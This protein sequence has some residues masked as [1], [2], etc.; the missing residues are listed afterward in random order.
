MVSGKDSDASLSSVRRP[1]ATVDTNCFNA[2]VNGG[3]ITIVLFS[4]EPGLRTVVHLVVETLGVGRCFGFNPDSQPVG[5]V[6]MV[7]RNRP[8]DNHVTDTLNAPASR[9]CRTRNSKSMLTSKYCTK[10]HRV[11]RQ[12]SSRTRTARLPTA[13]VSVATTRCQY[14]WEGEDRYPSPMSREK[15]VG[16][17]APCLGEWVPR[18]HVQWRG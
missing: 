2:E 16:T 1:H 7:V 17:K 9:T 6:I 5:M 14:W 3:L 8:H 12:H 4:F 10:A 15:R 13:C 18:S 11:T